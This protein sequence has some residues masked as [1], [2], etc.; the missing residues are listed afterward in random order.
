MKRTKMICQEKGHC[1]EHGEVNCTRTKKCKNRQ[2]DN[3]KKVTQIALE[4]MG[5]IGVTASEARQCVTTGVHC[6]PQV[7]AKLGPTQT[8]HFQYGYH[9]DMCPAAADKHEPPILSDSEDSVNSDDS[10]GWTS[11]EESE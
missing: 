5:A 10:H 3:A 7:D 4:N 8:Y 11:K 1:L 9:A 2:I 6:I